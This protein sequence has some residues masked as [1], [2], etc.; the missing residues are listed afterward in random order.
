DG[1]VRGEGAGVVLLKPLSKALA[2]GD[3]I[4]AVIR[5]TGIN[6]DGRTPG[7]TVPNGEAQEKLM[8]EVCRQA[9]LTPD[10]IQ[11]V[12][13]HGTGTK[14]GDPIEAESL[15][16]VFGRPEKCWIGS[17]K[18]NI[19]HLE[20]AAGISS[21]IKAVLMLQHQQIPPHLHLKNVNTKIDLD[22][23]GLRIPVKL[24][25]WPEHEG[26]A[27]IGM[28][29]FGYG[30][31]NAHVILTEAPP[32]Q[33]EAPTVL[34]K[35]L[36]LV[37][38]A[39]DAD[40]LA[41]M[42]DSH[43][44][45][46]ENEVSLPDYLYTAARRRTHHPHRM[47]VVFDSQEDLHDKL[48]AV[49]RHEPIS[50]IVSGVAHQ[51]KKLVFVYTGMGPQWWGM[52]RELLESEPV[53][54]DMLEKC[55]R[56]FTRFA[57]WSICE[58]FEKNTGDP[59]PDPKHAQPANFALQVALT[60][61]WRSYGVVPDAVV[62]HSAGE[63]AAAYISGSLSLEDALR[64]TYHRCRLMQRTVGKGKML[65][66]GISLEEA[67]IL[68]K[69]REDAISIAAVNS[70]TSVTLA[71]HP[72]A[73]V[74]AAAALEQQSKFNRFLRLEVAYHSYQM[75]P[76]HDEFMESLHGLE[77]HPPHLP[78]YST[79]TGQRVLS[80][81]QNAAY[82]WLNSRQGVQLHS[83]LKTL[84]DDGYD[85][86]L[87]V[88]PQ[89]VL[90][91][92]I[93]ETLRDKNIPGQSFYSLKR[94]QPERETFLLT[95]GSLYTHGC[96]PDWSR[97]FPSGGLTHLPNYPWHRE[98]LW[99]ENEIS[100]LDRIGDIWHPM[101]Q[102]P[103]PA[104]QPAW[105]GKLSDYYLD[106]LSDHQIEGHSLFPAAGY[107]E[108]GLA[109]AGQT[110]A[111]LE[112]LDLSKA[113]LLTGYPV[114]QVRLAEGRFGIYSR[115]AE[116]Y[117]DWTL[118]AAGSLLSR[119]LDP[120]IDH[121]NLY[122]IQEH[123][124]QEVSAETLYTRLKAH[125]LNYGRYFQ[126]VQTAYVGQGEVLAEV[127]VHEDLLPDLPDYRVHPA[128]LDSCF[129]TLLLTLSH[130]QEAK[131]PAV[132]MPVHVRQ[133]R[134]H[135][136]PGARVWCYTRLTY[137]S[138]RTL[139]GDVLLCDDEGRILVEVYG[140]RLQG[141]VSGEVGTQEN[142]L[143]ELRW[144][145][146]DNPRIPTESTTR[147]LIFSD[148]GRLANPLSRLIGERGVQCITVEPATTFSRHDLERLLESVVSHTPM[149]IVYF[150][151]MESLPED[152]SHF[153]GMADGIALMNLVQ[154]L[155]SLDENQPHQLIL[156][157][158]GTQRVLPDEK[159][160]TPG[161]GVLW[162]MGRVIVNEHAT[163]HARMIDVDGT[164]TGLHQLVDDMVYENHEPE[165][166]FRQGERYVNRLF[167]VEE[168]V[169]P[170]MTADHDTGFALQVTRPGILDSLEYH[171]IERRPP[172][173][174]EVE[175]RVQASALNFKDL[176]K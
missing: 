67:K 134:F 127:A 116:S 56:I 23:L 2:D 139:E 50:G 57:D 55:D 72:D 110:P 18:T 42:A 128:L 166:A 112:N 168:Q 136:Q 68:L 140:L 84:M 77:A 100:R 101:L 147:W 94:G 169:Q 158:S 154:A 40:S 49:G 163:L 63:I 11:Y 16:R 48:A 153:T 27:A 106:Y 30:G 141:L 24:E 133:V 83:A 145:R 103:L 157:T 32:K 99:V 33:E 5:A 79:V 54:R 155:H 25:P 109:A 131:N 45:L 59:M 171:E 93:Q 91:P 80:G 3:P 135:H 39:F 114:I 10:Q 144:E 120:R 170:P 143:Y 146:Q 142:W 108:M 6:Q 46:L 89:P 137:Q 13:A 82:W 75:T 52:G 17:V 115:P 78:L 129:Q 111:V 132:F 148:G 165:V 53:F 122:E 152:V 8:R 150:P 1:Y 156:V 36:P 149:G 87:E 151:R 138:A 20:A 31:T 172:Q 173:T 66:A 125:Q 130:Q 70:A 97:I 76:L 160:S 176:M 38:S 28:N 119:G 19:G 81:E 92:S 118:H 74:E 126:G 95:L 164:E 69:G 90:A 7:I 47:A 65:A 51:K 9:G 71:G 44:H 60:E 105:E 61:L 88:G 15:G 113:L 22:K 117:D 96:D 104:P 174:G 64:V 29:S 14:A 159:V 167:A 58:L 162:G 37:L 107:I 4:L 34:E 43:R 62:G 102:T 73:L 161:Q 123:C 12:E 86:F 175:V 124:S 41:A 26:L 121:L 21:L 35:S 85:T 98:S